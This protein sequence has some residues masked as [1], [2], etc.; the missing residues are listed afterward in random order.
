MVYVIRCTKCAKLYIDETGRTLDA[1]FKEH[2][3]NLLLTILAGHSI[4]NLRVKW[5]WLLFTDRVN[6]GD[7]M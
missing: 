5:L 1:R 4:H 3:I 7:L 6:D 2:V